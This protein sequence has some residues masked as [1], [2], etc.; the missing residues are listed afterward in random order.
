ME[1]VN[2]ADY[3]TKHLAEAAMLLTMRRVLVEIEREGNVCFFVFENKKRCEELSKQFFF[4]T[5]LVNA[6]DY[7]D[8]MNRLKNRI[9]SGG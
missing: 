4:D 3:R 7:Y 5:L 9:F 1:K 6:R 8:A 2:N